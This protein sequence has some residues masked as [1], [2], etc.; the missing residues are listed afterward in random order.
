MYAPENQLQD[1]RQVS[2]ILAIMASAMCPLQTWFTKF[3][4]V[5]SQHNNNFSWPH[6]GAQVNYFLLVWRSWNRS[7]VGKVL[8]DFLPTQIVPE[9]LHCS[10][11]P[12]FACDDIRGIQTLLLDHIFYH[13]LINSRPFAYFKGDPRSRKYLETFCSLRLFPSPFFSNPMLL[14]QCHPWHPDSKSWPHI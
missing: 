4:H 9:L 1:I 7:K 2:P 13:K 10:K 6:V 5:P 12:R 14:L 11:I 3:I 8:Q